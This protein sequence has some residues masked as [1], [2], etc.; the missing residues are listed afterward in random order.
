MASGD[1]DSL[2]TNI[3]LGENIDICIER[4]HNNNGIIHLVHTQ[5]FPKN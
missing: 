3:L 5:K 2:F 1:V 4:L